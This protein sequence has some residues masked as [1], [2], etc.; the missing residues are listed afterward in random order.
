[1]LPITLG[2]RPPTVVKAGPE[3]ARAVLSRD[4]NACQFCGFVTRTHAKVVLHPGKFR[5]ASEQGAADILKPELFVTACP[6]CDLT[7]DLEEAARLDAGAICYVPE[8]TQAEVNHVV[9]ACYAWKKMGTSEHAAT[10]SMVQSWFMHRQFAVPKIAGKRTFAPKNM[11]RA[12]ADLPEDIYNQR[13][14]AVKHLRFVA[15]IDALGDAGEQWSENIYRNIPVNSW[16][17]LAE[18][19]LKK[20]NL[21]SKQ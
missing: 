11:A 9:H 8:L 6:M 14:K 15:D 17:K 5:E 12:L 19:Y 10:A 4:K 2:L 7:A 20:I 21:P 3:T 18:Q 16:A 1:M 13:H